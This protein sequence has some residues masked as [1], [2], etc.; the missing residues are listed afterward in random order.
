MLELTKRGRPHYH[1]VLWIPKGFTPPLPDK[2]GWWKK[3]HTQ[4]VWARSPVGYVA[5]YASKGG[6]TEGLPKGARLYGYLGLNE[7]MLTVRSWYVAPQWLKDMAEYGC[8]LVKRAGWWVNK[9]WGI[10]YRSP[11]VLD[12]L[13]GGVASLRWVGWTEDDIRFV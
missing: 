9:T 6:E 5:K 7:Q 8:R 2:Q 1:L 3:G 13:A 12:S 11:W 10:A 4:A